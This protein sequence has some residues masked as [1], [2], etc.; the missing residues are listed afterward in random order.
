[1][2]VIATGKP[3]IFLKSKVLRARVQGKPFWGARR[4]R[5]RN[6]EKCKRRVSEGSTRKRSAG[7]SSVLVEVWVLQLWNEDLM[8]RDFVLI[9]KGA[10]QNT[11][12]YS[13]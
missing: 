1:M 4:G 8:R 5:D 13:K 12:N 9:L 3:S 10:F 11:P 6:R 7:A 2:V